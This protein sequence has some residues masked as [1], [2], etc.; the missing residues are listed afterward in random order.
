[1]PIFFNLNFF[2]FPRAQLRNN[3]SSGSSATVNGTEC[4]VDIFFPFDPYLLRTS[5][6]FISPIFREWTDPEEAIEEGAGDEDSEQDS[7]DGFIASAS[8]MSFT[9]DFS[10]DVLAYLNCARTRT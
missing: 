8:P 5:S 3:G 1:M 9:P 7:D 6:A 4:L 10:A 2:S